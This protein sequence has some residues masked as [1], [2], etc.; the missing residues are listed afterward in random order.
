MVGQ[1]FFNEWHMARSIQHPEKELRFTRS[2]Q[3]ALFAVIGAV[4]MGA[5]MTILFSA[6]YRSINPNLP[7]GAWAILPFLT[8]VIALRF[9][10]QLAYHAYLILSPIGIEIF[11][12]FRAKSGMNLVPWGQIAEANVDQA[13]QLLTLHF[14]SEKTSGIHLSLRPIRKESRCLLA[15]ALQGRLN[16]NSQDEPPTL[17]TNS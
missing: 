3:A 2:R 7:H 9:S 12:F 1:L 11:P 14:T 13:K 16:P 8:G 15:K 6:S 5:A 10:S 17:P 4:M